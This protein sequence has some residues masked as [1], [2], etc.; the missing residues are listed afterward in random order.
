MTTSSLA[1][2]T[3]EHCLMA[4]ETQLSAQL[5]AIEGNT[6]Y[7]R[8]QLSCVESTIASLFAALEITQAELA[9]VRARNP[10]GRG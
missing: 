4:Q 1:I 10:V 3:A 9:S 6:A 7:L 8:S 5:G 2:S